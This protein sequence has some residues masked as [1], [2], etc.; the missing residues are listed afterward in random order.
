MHVYATR[1]YLRQVRLIF[2][3]SVWYVRFQNT[4]DVPSPL[5]LP[6][7]QCPSLSLYLV[8]PSLYL[9]LPSGSCTT[10]T[11]FQ[12]PF[13]FGQLILGGSTAVE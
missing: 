3:L 7:V 12:S 11:S 5:P 8:P 6:L 9:C 4:Q 2:L 13:L 1:V 10:Y